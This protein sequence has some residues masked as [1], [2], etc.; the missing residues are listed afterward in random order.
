MSQWSDRLELY[1]DIGNMELLGHHALLRS[2]SRIQHTY[3]YS[4]Q[5]LGTMKVALK[6]ALAALVAVSCLAQ[7]NNAG[8]PTGPAEGIPDDLKDP[9][10]PT[11]GITP[12]MK[13]GDHTDFRFQLLS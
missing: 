1:K 3:H 10:G 13:V 7:E 12:D 8:K 6:L 2:H 9:E 5:I 4:A 11:H